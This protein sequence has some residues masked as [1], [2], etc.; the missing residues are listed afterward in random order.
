[1]RR[2]GCG[3][4]NTNCAAPPVQSRMQ[5]VCKKAN[6]QPGSWKQWSG[7]I[8]QG[9]CGT[10]TRIKPQILTWTTIQKTGSCS[11]VQTSCPEPAKESRKMCSCSKAECSLG[12]WSEWEG[13]VEQGRCG[14]QKRRRVYTKETVY[15]QHDKQCPSLPQNCLAPVEESRAMCSC[16]YATCSLDDW[17]QWEPQE[18]EHG[19]CGQQQTRKKTYSLTWA[20]QSHAEQC[21]SLPQTCPDDIV[22]KRTQCKCVYRDSCDVRA[23]SE[24]DK[25]L[26]EEGC[27]VQTRT[28]SYV[29]PLKHSVQKDCSGLLTSCI[30]EPKESR[31]YCKCKHV[32]CTLA[33]WSNWSSAVLAVGR[34]GKEKRIRHYVAE[35]KF[36]FAENCDGLTTSCPASQEES[37]TMCKCPYVTCDISDWNPWQ[38]ALPADSC[39]QQIR[40]KNVTEKQHEKIQAANCDGLQTNCP[41]IPQETRQWCN[42]SFREN[43]LLNDWSDWTGKIPNGGCAVQIRTRDY[44]KSIEYFE[45]ETCDGLDSCPVIREETRTKCNCNEVICS[46]GNWTR[47]N[48]NPETNCYQEIRVKNESSGFKVVEQSENCD[49]ISIQCSSP[50]IEKREDCISGG[51]GHVIHTSEAPPTTE[52]STTTVAPTTGFQPATFVSLGCFADT[53]DK[54]K[55]PRAMPILYANFR[56]SIDWYDLS[57]TVQACA[58]EAKTKRL[59]YFSVQFYGECWSGANSKQT[60]AKYGESDKCYQGVGMEKTNAVYRLENMPACSSELQFSA[61][62]STGDVNG[63]TW[64]AGDAAEYQWIVVDLGGERKITGVGTQGGN[65][66]SW[67]TLYKLEWSEEGGSW[68]TYHEGDQEI[69]PGNSDRFTLETQWLIKPITAGFLRFK[70][71]SWTSTHVCMKIKVYGCAV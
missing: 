3:G 66:D 20:Y 48:Y 4:L 43:C 54:N 62:V 70:P 37:R 33:E 30:T 71:L 56:S 10:Q 15:E 49:G 63:H 45:R 53:K 21:P 59:E 14:T 7:V 11:G 69:F 8:K 19:K 24:W 29:Y 25:P 22:E 42:C 36:T 55:H 46:W 65:V 2:H 52:P 47:T 35:E 57:K 23:W 9:T 1:M 18:L 13:K 5:C 51:G 64:C 58:E 17:S 67:V 41:P 60:F 44:N 34:C 16:K 50:E 26:T 32:A 38:G 28:R 12:D 40:T 68:K 61:S 27:Q 39:A 31:N 6:C